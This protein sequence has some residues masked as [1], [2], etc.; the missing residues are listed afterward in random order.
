MQ[1]EQSFCIFWLKV[2][3][4][5]INVLLGINI[6]LV[7]SKP[8]DTLSEKSI[9]FNIS[10]LIHK[11]LKQSPC[12]SSKVEHVHE[13]IRDHFTV[14]MGTKQSEICTRQPGSRCTKQP[15]G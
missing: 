13:L 10:P 6:F 2:L 11:K 9:E 15:K 14:V 8:I 4:E 7:K 12:T 3:V 1:L 5:A